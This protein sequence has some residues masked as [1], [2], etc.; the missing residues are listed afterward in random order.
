MTSP[1]PKAV[2]KAATPLSRPGCDPTCEK[3][4]EHIYV[5]CYGEP[6]LVSD[7]DWAPHDRR[8]DNYPIRHYVGWTRRHPPI[9]RVRQHGAR[10]GHFIAKIVP[11]D[12]Q[13]EALV[14]AAETCPRCAGSLD[15]YAESPS[16]PAAAHG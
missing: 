1:R 7:R 16:R 8:G 5:L 14:K 12:K 6:T 4:A 9:A 15:Y 11:G 10:S 3:H 13:D 2:P